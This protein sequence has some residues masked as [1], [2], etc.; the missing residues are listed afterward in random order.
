MLITRSVDSKNLVFQ[1]SNT[2]S[3]LAYFP[4][5]SEVEFCSYLSSRLV[6]DRPMLINDLD[7]QSQNM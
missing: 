4:E 5:Y 2:Y 7:A 1:E 6:E 3:I